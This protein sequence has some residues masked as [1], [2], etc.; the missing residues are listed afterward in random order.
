MIRK[1]DPFVRRIFGLSAFEEMKRYPWSKTMKFKHEEPEYFFADAP[2]PEPGTTYHFEEKGAI[3]MATTKGMKHCIFPQFEAQGFKQCLQA[4]DD[5]YCTHPRFKD[6][7]RMALH[8]SCCAIGGY[9]YLAGSREIWAE[10]VL[11]VLR[12]LNRD[13][14]L[15]KIEET[16]RTVKYRKTK[17][18]S[19]VNTKLQPLPLDKKEHYRVKAANQYILESDL[20]KTELG[21][22]I[23]YERDAKSDEGD[24]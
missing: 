13:I 9:I 3:I 11:G 19:F 24:D 20:Q 6:P 21:E 5:F 23:T 16:L 22:L 8:I 10:N 2:K 7:K 18:G 12:L 14:S 4:V 17:H 1:H 15:S